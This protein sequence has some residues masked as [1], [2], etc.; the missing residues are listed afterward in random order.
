MGLAPPFNQGIPQFE[1]MAAQGQAL[2]V[3]VLGQFKAVVIRLFSILR[4]ILCATV[5]YGYIQPL[6]VYHLVTALHTAYATR[7]GVFKSYGQAIVA[8]GMYVLVGYVVWQAPVHV[9]VE[10]ASGEESSP[11]GLGDVDAQPEL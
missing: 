6:A 4:V 10:V 1:A 3:N 11:L 9:L 5:L 7:Q 2:P 8:M